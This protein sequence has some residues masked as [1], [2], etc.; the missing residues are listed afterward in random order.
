MIIS[1]HIDCRSATRAVSVLV[2]P[3]PRSPFSHRPTRVVTVSPSPSISPGFSTASL[4]VDSRNVKQSGCGG[5][6]L[7][8][9]GASLHQ[10]YLIRCILTGFIHYD[11][12]RHADPST[13][14]AP[15][16]AALPSPSLQVHFPVTM[17]QAQ[18]SIGQSISP[19][20]PMS[21]SSGTTIVELDPAVSPHS[22]SDTR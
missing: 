15:S 19:V 4:L 1:S 5:M 17:S 11:T 6:R 20:G 13:F 9:M 2:V 10:P 7:W 3:A 8:S 18:A 12:C 22:L 16:R 14:T 21:S